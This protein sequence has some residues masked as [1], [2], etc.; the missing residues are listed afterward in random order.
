MSLANMAA[1]NVRVDGC[2]YIFIYMHQP[3]FSFPNVLKNSVCIV[4][5]KNP[6]ISFVNL[7]A[8]SYS[9]FN[10]TVNIPHKNDFL[11][12]LSYINYLIQIISCRL[13]KQI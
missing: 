12:I 4:P 5:S 6:R 10:S 9:V 11:L 2:I 3:P 13:D 8:R 1:N 7:N